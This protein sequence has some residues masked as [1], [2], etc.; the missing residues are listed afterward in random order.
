MNIEEYE[1]FRRYLNE[2]EAKLDA[3]FLDSA[4]IDFL[5]EPP[6]KNITETISGEGLN[7]EWV[8]KIKP[9]SFPFVEDLLK[10]NESLDPVD[11]EKYYLNELNDDELIE[12]LTQ[13][14][15]W[16]TFDFSMAVEILKLRGHKIS[17]AEIEKYKKERIEKIRTPKQISKIQIIGI[18]VFMLA[19]GIV[20]SAMAYSIA[21][22]KKTDP[23]GEIFYTYNADSRKT[24]QSF[25]IAGIVIFIM[26][27]LYALGLIQ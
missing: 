22:E 16:S 18:S 7:I 6:G 19:G 13:F 23:T 9:K 2:E 20:G 14:D 12:I 3:D 26:Q 4:N 25:F 10:K 15:E 21:H 8:L 24:A 5:L 1:V 17:E 27:F 11:P